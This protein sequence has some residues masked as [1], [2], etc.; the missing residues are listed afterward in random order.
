MQGWLFSAT[1]AETEPRKFWGIRRCNISETWEE[2]V[3][4]ADSFLDSDADD[5]S[6]DSF[7]SAFDDAVELAIPPVDFGNNVEGL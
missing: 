7:N 3:D 2:E 6:A 4:M 1:D 5:G